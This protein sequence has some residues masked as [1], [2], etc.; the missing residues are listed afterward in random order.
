MTKF[1]L[2][3]WFFCQLCGDRYGNREG[4]AD[5]HVSKC[6]A[7]GEARPL[8]H[9]GRFGLSEAEAREILK[10]AASE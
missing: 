6:D 4:R 5:G 10:R 9:T 7:C 2:K 8:G 1:W 3:G